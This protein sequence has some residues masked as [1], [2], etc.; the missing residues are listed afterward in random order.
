ML[1]SCNGGKIPGIYF[2]LTHT[3]TDPVS[4]E[5]LKEGGTPYRFVPRKGLYFKEKPTSFRRLFYGNRTFN[6][7]DVGFWDT[8]DITDMR[9]MFYDAT[10]FNQ[11]L[12]FNTKNVYNMIEMF[13]EAKSFNQD[14]SWWDVSR[15]G[16]AYISFWRYSGL[17]ERNVPKEFRNFTGNQ[18]KYRW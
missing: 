14:I 16:D 13:E 10:N 9:G 8:S 7:P 12:Q 15:V 11:P 4:S 18:H 3:D 17:S 1:I 2:P 5:Y 6:D